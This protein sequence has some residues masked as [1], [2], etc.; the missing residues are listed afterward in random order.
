VKRIDDASLVNRS[1]NSNI[2]GADRDNRIEDEGDGRS[3]IS[4]TSLRLNATSTENIMVHYF[5]KP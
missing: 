1:R 2:A 3:G 4:N 5:C